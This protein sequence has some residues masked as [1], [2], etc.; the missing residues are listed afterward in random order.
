[1]PARTIWSIQALSDDGILKLYIGTSITIISETISSFTA[2]SE[3]DT[4]FLSSRDRFSAGVIN[5]VK[6]TSFKCGIS[7]F[8]R[9][10]TVTPFSGCSVL[11]FSSI[12]L[13]NLKLWESLPL[14]LVI[15]LKI[16][17]FIYYLILVQI[18]E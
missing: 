16:F 8:V 6:C 2:S 18:S 14:K 13:L 15:N 5:E 12:A 1:M 4:A 10:L 9:S 11:I 17:I 7:L 3:K